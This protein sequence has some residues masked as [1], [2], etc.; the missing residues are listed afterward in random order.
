MTIMIGEPS[1]SYQAAEQPS[2]NTT[3]ESI[4]APPLLLLTPSTWLKI[5]TEAESENSR[6]ITTSCTTGKIFKPKDTHCI[7]QFDNTNR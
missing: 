6:T 7:L 4:K 5:P 3:L 1:T 2:L